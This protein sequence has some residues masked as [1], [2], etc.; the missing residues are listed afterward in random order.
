VRLLI[1]GGDTPPVDQTVTNTN[2]NH[3]E[4]GALILDLHRGAASRLL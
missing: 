3:D 4:V 2:H 1:T